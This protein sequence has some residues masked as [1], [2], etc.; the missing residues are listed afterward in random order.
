MKEK[1][2]VII[3]LQNT[4]SALESELA[5]LT[6]SAAFQPH[7]EITEG[8]KKG[9]SG[10][11]EQEVK[12]LKAELE[13]MKGKVMAKTDLL[14]KLLQSTQKTSSSDPGEFSTAFSDLYEA[15]SLARFELEGL[16]YLLKHMR[17]GEEFK[18]EVLESRRMGQK[19]W[20]GVEQLRAEVKAVSGLVGEVKEE[21]TRVYFEN[22]RI[23]WHS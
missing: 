22:C 3:A 9:N 15:A 13:E 6:L 18:L 19:K 2:Q 20:T 10:E 4:N 16:Q 1:D 17:I 21:L 23:Q 7:I 12:E 5:K 11:K 14:F 8:E